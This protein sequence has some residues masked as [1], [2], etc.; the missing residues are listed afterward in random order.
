MTSSQKCRYA[1]WNHT[2]QLISDPITWRITPKSKA[3]VAVVPPTVLPGSVQVVTASSSGIQLRV[4]DTQQNILLKWLGGLPDDVLRPTVCDTGTLVHS[5]LYNVVGQ[6]M[7]VCSVVPASGTQVKV[8]LTASV[9]RIG[10]LYKTVLCVVDVLTSD[11][12]TI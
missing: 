1:L 6:N 10:P 11:V 12:A 7:K 8:R 9:Q 2:S 3:F 4:N 5:G